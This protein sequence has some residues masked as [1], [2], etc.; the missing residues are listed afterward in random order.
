M[1][2]LEV[3]PTA[4]V[5]QS[6][7]ESQQLI[8]IAHFPDGSSRDVTRD[9]VCDTSNFEVATVSST[10]R[11]EAVRRGEAAALVRYEGQYGTAPIT[12]VGTRDGYAWKESPQ[13]NFIDAHVDAKLKKMKLWASDLCSDAEFL[14]RISLDLTGVPPDIDQTRAFVAD[15]RDSRSKRQREGGGAVRS[16]SAFVDHWT[17]KWSDL[18]LEQA[19]VRSGERG[20]GVPQL[21]PP[22]AVRKTSPTTNS[23]TS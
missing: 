11:I 22:G 19:E 15:P 5:L 6:A 23:S 8:V 1:T 3:F 7:K 10:G 9:A 16:S 12:V 4:P 20:L 14:R 2:Q 17:L 18:L 21:D 13:F